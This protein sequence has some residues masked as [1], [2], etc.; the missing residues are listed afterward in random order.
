MFHQ[1][2]LR[3]NVLLSEMFAGPGGARIGAASLAPYGEDLGS[4]LN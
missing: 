1:S 2:L 3:D 4:A